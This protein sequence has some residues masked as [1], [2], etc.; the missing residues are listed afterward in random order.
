M[1][2][3][4]PLVLAQT[5]VII[6]GAPWTLV[7]TSQSAGYPVCV[8][9][10]DGNTGLVGFSMDTPFGTSAYI[11]RQFTVPPISPTFSMTVWGNYDP[12]TVTIFVNG[13]QLDTFTPPPSQK[14]GTPETKRYD[15]SQWA[16]QTVTIR[17]SQTSG[18]TTGTFCWYKN[19]VM[20]GGSA[21]QQ[22]PT[23]LVPIGVAIV[24]AAAIVGLVVYAMRRR[25]RGGIAGP[26]PV[27]STKLPAYGGISPEAAE[28][29][30]RLRRMLDLGLITQEDYEDQ[31]KRLGAG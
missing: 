17:I 20:T 10:R 16:G 25:G 19:I 15:L 28:K 2:R 5:T 30:R 6:E 9:Q 21:P 24:L 23:P 1:A 8:T 22:L 31:R 18:G 13:Q 27:A 11:E 29:L 26:A 12:V 7:V 4:P 14:G 3:A